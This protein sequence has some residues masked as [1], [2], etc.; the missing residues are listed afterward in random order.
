M[1]DNKGFERKISHHI[2]PYLKFHSQTNRYVRFLITDRW[3]REV[4]LRP[5]MT[6]GFNFH[7]KDNVRFH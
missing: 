2:Q 4:L 5:S 7:T 6:L 1:R 3:V